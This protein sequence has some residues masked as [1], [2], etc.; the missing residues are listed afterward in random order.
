MRFTLAA[1]VSAAA[2]AAAISIVTPSNWTTKGPNVIT[3][4]YVNTD[5]TSFA[6]ILVNQN[7]NLVPTSITLKANVTTKL[8]TLTVKP[9]QRSP[10]FLA[11][12]GYQIKYMYWARQHWDFEL[13]EFFIPQ[14]HSQHHIATLDSRADKYGDIAPARNA[15]RPGAPQTPQMFSIPSNAG[16]LTNFSI[17]A[18]NGFNSTNPFLGALLAT[19][20]P[21]AEFQIGKGSFNFAYLN[22]ASEIPAGSKASSAG[23]NN[24]RVG[25]PVETS[26]YSIDCKTLK[27]TSRWIN[28]DGGKHETLVPII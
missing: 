23:T 20:S 16:S 17:S 13:R 26:I 2:S 15:T 24:I 5:P 1:L 3:F 27:I 7:G 10:A 11:G 12:S 18:V 6:A 25:L 8:L 21:L 14:L 22:A 9:S 4:S 19:D 28:T